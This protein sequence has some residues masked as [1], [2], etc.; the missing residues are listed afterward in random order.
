[1]N[2]YKGRMPPK[3]ELTLKQ[4]QQGV[5]NDVL[6]ETGSIHNLSKITMMIVDIERDRVNSLRLHMS[7][8]QEEFRQ[9]RRDRVDARGRLRRLES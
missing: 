9:I 3:I 8:S 1:M 6:A 2:V 5:S 7:L 4:S